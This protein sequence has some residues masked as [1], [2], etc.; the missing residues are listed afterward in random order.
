[1]SVGAIKQHSTV[2][3]KE[4]MASKR[5]HSVPYRALLFVVVKIALARFLAMGSNSES[6]RSRG[7]L[8][9]ALVLFTNGWRGFVGANLDPE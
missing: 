2:A 3:C 6:A 8:A 7:G 4:S 1:M 9:G 5:C